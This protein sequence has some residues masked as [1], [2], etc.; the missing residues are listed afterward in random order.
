[1]KQNGFI[2]RHYA[3]HAEHF[4]ND[5]V[6]T[7]RIRI[8]ES[9]FDESTADHWRHARAYECAEL[10]ATQ[11]SASW[12]TVG[13]GRWGLDAIRI[14][15]KGYASVL[16]TDISASLLAEAHARGLIEGY[17]IE[18]AERLSFDDGSF[19]YVFCKESLH[20]FP[21]PY[22]ALYEMIRVARKGV[23]LVEPNDTYEFEGLG[24]RAAGLGRRARVAAG[25]RLIM[26]VMRAAQPATSAAQQRR[27]RLRYNAPDWESSGN[28]VYAVSRRE[29]EKVAL[30]LNLP[31][32]VFKG[33]NDHYVKGVE[34]EPADA[35]RSPV[36]RELLEI[37]QGKDALYRA[38]LADTNLLMAGILLEPLA[39]DAR[40]RFEGAEWEVVDLPANP[41]LAR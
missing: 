12:L 26:Q 24:E 6:D 37:T 17:A 40:Q 14:R 13:D 33:L 3:R 25:L 27:P 39:A 11:A 2:E 41:F 10:L 29:I 7:E 36:F 34:F 9:W 21:R 18:N 23:F 28:Y 19:D 22:M 16:P 8:A 30:G 35:A 5:L 4:A 15:K 1:M 31:Q 38:G 20:H 32:I